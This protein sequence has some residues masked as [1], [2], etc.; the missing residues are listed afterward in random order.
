MS[1][2]GFQLANSWGGDHPVSLPELSREAIEA[3]VRRSELYDVRARIGGATTGR[4][5]DDVLD[6]RDQTLRLG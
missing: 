5:L 4:T 3:S 6:A 2:F 1:F